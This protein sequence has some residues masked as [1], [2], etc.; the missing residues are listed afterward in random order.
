M[1][2]VWCGKMAEHK[3]RSRF[4]GFVVGVLACGLCGCAGT[5]VHEARTPL[6]AEGD[7]AG[8]Y[9]AETDLGF[10]QIGAMEDIAAH[11]EMPAILDDK[12]ADFFIRSGKSDGVWVEGK[13]YF[14]GTLEG[15][16][17][18]LIDPL[19]IGPVHLT[20]DIER[21]ALLETPS[22][23]TYT[24]HVRMRYIFSIEFD[25]AAEIVPLYEGENQVGWYYHSEKV[26]GTRFISRISTRL[27]V[28][29][30]DGGRFEVSFQSVNE[31]TMDKEN[32]AR[33]HLEG[34]F[35]YWLEKS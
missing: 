2:G 23:T 22:R 20:K 33:G 21:G 15:V 14:R 32:E 8:S 19:I 9:E 34:L 16:Y 30:I 11:V 1:I 13:G 6:A 4:A 29:V 3:K 12:P 25:L 18:D 7:I 26:A 28:R 31:A 5:A 10:R 17:A 24:M 27:I 35:K